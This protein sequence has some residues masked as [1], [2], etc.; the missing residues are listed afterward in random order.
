MPPLRP[1]AGAG[2][3]KSPSAPSGF[4]SEAAL[5]PTPSPGLWLSPAT[6]RTVGKWTR[7]Q[8]PTTLT[9]GLCP[10]PTGQSCVQDTP[11]SRPFRP[12]LLLGTTSRHGA[13]SEFHPGSVWGTPRWAPCRAA[14]LLFSARVGVCVL[15][16]SPANR[17]SFISLLNPRAWKSPVP[18]QVL[19]KLSRKGTK[20]ERRDRRLSEGVKVVQSRRLR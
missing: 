13:V 12:L 1:P 15:T 7:S 17:S 2:V 8:L 3:R 5:C 10:G 6:M 4:C 18:R 19:R 20:N 9:R 16:K 11:T 14:R